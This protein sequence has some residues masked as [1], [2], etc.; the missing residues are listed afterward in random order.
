MAHSEH[1][2]QKKLQAK[3]TRE[4]VLER[5]K[6][7][8]LQSMGIRFQMSSAAKCPVV[9][10][11][12]TT[13]IFQNGMGIALLVRRDPKGKTAIAMF[14]LDVYCLGVKN[15][16]FRVNTESEAKRWLNELYSRG[17]TWV[18]VSPEYVRKLVEDT[19]VY[20]RS[21]GF[22]P[23]PDNS[24]AQLLF[25]DLDAAKCTETFTFGSKGKPMFIAGPNDSPARIN[26][27]M[28]VLTRKLGQE[29]FHFLLPVSAESVSVGADGNLE[30][31]EVNFLDDEDDFDEDDDGDFDED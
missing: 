17:D 4:K 28:A 21:L 14:L 20:A 1:R 9:R 25:G 24:I 10:A 31:S 7:E 12:V 8:Q 23:H 30:V 26:Q 18:D 27:I 13:S 19:I 11:R 29:G 22:A 6:H 15:A 5:R 2:R 3:R 16:A